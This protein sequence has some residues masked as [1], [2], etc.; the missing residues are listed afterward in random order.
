MT[1]PDFRAERELRARGVIQG[2][3]RMLW[4]KLVLGWTKSPAEAHALLVHLNDKYALDGRDPD[5]WANIGWCFGLHDRPW[6]ERAI[7][8]NVRAMTTRSARGKLDFEGYIT[9]RWD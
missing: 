7:L 5:G 9:R 1:K 4:G 6:P 2:Y 8:G 3:A